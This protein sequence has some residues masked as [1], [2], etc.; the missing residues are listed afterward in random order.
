MGTGAAFPDE[1]GVIER[2]HTAWR[3]ARAEKIGFLVDAREY[4]RAF[5]EAVSKARESVFILAW[6]IDSRLRLLRG[7]ESGTDG[8]P[9]AKLL[10]GALDR[11][12][13]LH[14]NIL[15][16]DYSTIYALERE[17]LTQLKMNWMMH[18]RLHFRFD[19]NHP[20]TGSLH[21]K[22]VVI[23][24]RLAFVGGIDLG[25]RRWDTPAPPAR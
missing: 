12:S 4:Y 17:F 24:D 10:A 14:V 20:P 1:L 18:D 15:C 25:P 19:R 23:D 13:D 21:E 3:I 9:L 2:D 8:C 5:V 6:D 7:R 16:W 22:I 11:N